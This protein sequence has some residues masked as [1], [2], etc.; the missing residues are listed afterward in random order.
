MADE[1]K[2]G[3]MKSALELAMERL[4]KEG[5]A[6]RPLSDEQKARIAEVEKELKA[7]IAELDILTGQRLEEARAGADAE[8]I[9]ELEQGRQN[10]VARLQRQAEE[11]KER[12]REGR[13]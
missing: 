2:G 13:E 3:G 6:I 11:R 7:K 5:G 4:E 1:K 10:E 12:I 9:A 8:R